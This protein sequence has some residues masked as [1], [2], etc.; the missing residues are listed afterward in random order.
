MQS[1]GREFDSRGRMTVKW[2]GHTTLLQRWVTVCGQVNRLG[3]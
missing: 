1:K 3:I 2:L